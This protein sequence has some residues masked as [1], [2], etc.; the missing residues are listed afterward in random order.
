MK[1]RV[2][3]DVVCSQTLCFW[4]LPAR[5]EVTFTRKR[6]KQKKSLFFTCFLAGFRV[7]FAEEIGPFVEK[8]VA[9]KAEMLPLHTIISY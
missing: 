1:A 2:K 8:I 5:K 9:F 7:C 4:A 6:K 3:D